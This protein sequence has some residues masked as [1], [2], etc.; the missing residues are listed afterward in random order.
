METLSTELEHTEHQL[1][2]KTELATRLQRELSELRGEYQHQVASWREK[3]TE[4]K[5]S[6]HHGDV[7]RQSLIQQVERSNQELS[8]LS[9]QLAEH[10]KF[11]RELKQ[12]QT[13]LER[14]KRCM[15]ELESEKERTEAKLTTTRDEKQSLLVDL[16]QEKTR[17]AKLAGQLK[18]LER[19][20][21][22]EV[23]KREE[24]EMLVGQLGEEVEQLRR[25]L[26]TSR[27]RV[28]EIETQAKEK[29][30]SVEDTLGHMQ[31][32]LAKRA[33]QV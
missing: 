1:L 31:R 24:A 21:P 22:G 23:G 3:E 20:L 16:G 9:D 32:E 29:E 25:E 18:Q 27:R 2:D 6:L 4:L 26:E 10:Q 13:D 17:N 15:L 14:L 8:T 19:Q 28:V 33:Q 11:P 12:C 7:L 30:G 5:Q